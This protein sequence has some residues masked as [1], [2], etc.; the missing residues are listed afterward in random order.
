MKKT[1]LTS[2]KY[3]TLFLFLLFAGCYVNAQNY[4]ALNYYRGIYM[5]DSYGHYNTVIDKSFKKNI[6]LFGMPY[7]GIMN[8]ESEV[9]KNCDFLEISV[10]T[11][12]KIGFATIRITDCKNNV[13]FS[14]EKSYLYL[15][16]ASIINELLKD[17]AYHSAYEYAITGVSFDDGNLSE[18]VETSITNMAISSPNNNKQSNTIK[19]LPKK[20]VIIKE[21]DSDNIEI[22]PD[23]LKEKHRYRYALIIGNQDYTSF[24]KTSG[25]Q[26]EV[27]FAISDA[28]LF[29]E[30]AQACFGIPED[31][32]VYIKN[33]TT[34]S[35]SQ[36]IDMVSRVLE[37]TD[38]KGEL[39]FYY[40]G[41]GFT[42]SN[43]APFLI[44]CDVAGNDS[45]YSISLNETI[46]KFATTNCDIYSFID[47]CYSGGGR[48]EDLVA[49]RSLSVEPNST[50]LPGDVLVFA[51]STGSQPSCAYPEKRHGLFTYYLL[52]GLKQNKGNI[53]LGD[54]ADFVIKEV[55]IKSLFLMQE[56]DPIIRASLSFE[57]KWRNKIL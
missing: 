52:K 57:S 11:N 28:S 34:T 47:A 3:L 18:Q 44:P 33:A 46:Q 29:S 31:N 41:H 5:T 32:I 39:I 45:D 55:G 22:V 21:P 13:H 27:D 15:S 26:M 23:F 48:S 20:P 42:D 25:K 2:R 19:T 49:H 8:E 14:K 12:N 10:L 6:T 1:N 54:L 36:H 24:K 17:L 38:G 40:A 50:Y 4:K 30:Y 7:L 9:A 53:T 35:M 43:G 37:K 51:S 56:Q 16:Y